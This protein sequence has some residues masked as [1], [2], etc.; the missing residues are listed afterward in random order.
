[1]SLWIS[2]FAFTVFHAIP[3]NNYKL[4]GKLLI[5][6]C[7]GSFVDHYVIFIQKELNFL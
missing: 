3:W 7:S 4:H 6:D 2:W 1:M 5:D